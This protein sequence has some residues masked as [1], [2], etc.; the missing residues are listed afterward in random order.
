M[1]TS[2]IFV[3]P[4]RSLEHVFDVAQVIETI[5]KMVKPGGKIL[6]SWPIA[7]ARRV[8]TRHSST[9]SSIL[10]ET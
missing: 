7:I 8:P 4:Q 9:G 6:A 2:S 10:T 1:F 3:T 5:V